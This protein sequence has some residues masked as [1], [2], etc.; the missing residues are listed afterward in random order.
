MRCLTFRQ[1]LV[2]AILLIGVWSR[3]LAQSK[4]PVEPPVG[5]FGLSRITTTDGKPVAIDL[6]LPNETCGVCHERELKEL[7]GSMHSIAHTEGLYRSFAELG[8]K[9]AGDKTYGQCAGCHSASGVVSGLI[10]AKHDPELPDEAKTGV[11]CDVCHQIKAL[12][13]TKGPWGEPG[14][15]SFV[16]EAGRIKFGDSGEVAENRLHTGEKREFFKSA[17]FCASCHTVIHPVNGL[18]I[19]TTYEEWKSSVYAKNGIQCQDCHMRSVEDALKVAQTLRPVVVKGQRVVDGAVR[20]I[21][22]HFFVGG[23]A[24]ADLLGGGVA[25]AKMAEVRLKSAARIDLKTPAKAIAGKELALEVVVQNVAAGHN[26]P[27]GVTE[28]RRMWVDLQIRDHSGKLLY[29]VGDLDEQGDLRPERSGSGRKPLIVRE[30][31]P[32]DRGRW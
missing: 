27:T 22:P 28:L 21:H 7:Q 25:H 10:P 3:L 5:P 26:L 19:E 30:R 13:G 17:E 18:R 24:N 23:N 15:A 6:F 9:E 29:Q 1:S 2:I 32:S 16:I 8:R 14:N 12:T 20:E 4:T 11:A 31:R